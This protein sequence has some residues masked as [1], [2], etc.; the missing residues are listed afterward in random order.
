[1]KDEDIFVAIGLKSSNLLKGTEDK[2]VVCSF[3]GSV[4]SFLMILYL[5]KDFVSF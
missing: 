3:M 1:L 5:G 2:V 4:I